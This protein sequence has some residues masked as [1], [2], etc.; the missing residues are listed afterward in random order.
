MTEPRISNIF[1]LSQQ[2]VKAIQKEAEAERAMQVESEEDLGQYFELATFNPMQQAQRFR[3]LKELHQ[4]QEGKPEEA[5]ET[6]EVIEK[7]VDVEKVDEVAERF[8]RNNFE[9]NPKTLRVLRSQVTKADNSDEILKKVDS[10]YKDASLAD[11][12]LDFLI[13]TSETAL[14]AATQEAK[15]KF[16]KD[17]GKEIR[18]GRNMGAQSREFSKELG[19]PTSLRDLYRDIILNPREPVKLFDELAEKFRYPKLK[20]AINFMLHSLGADMKSKGPSIQRA[21]LKRLLDE[22]RSM[23]G[24]LGIFRFFQSR[25]RLIQREFTSYNLILPS[26]LDFEIIARIFVKLIAERFMSPEKILQTAKLLGISEEAAAQM[27]IYSQ[28][29]DAIKQVAP[30]YFRDPRHREEILRALIDTIEKLEDQME[31]EEEEEEEEK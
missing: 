31:E 29:R 1:P 19:S 25:M 6:E 14:L 8:H 18:A 9:M 11:E 26:R 10:V 17:K 16:N 20:T 12:A 22:T 2:G 4:K 5:E 3:N 7:I 24:I 23:Q 28:M 27:V 13:E 30:K 21:E 15:E